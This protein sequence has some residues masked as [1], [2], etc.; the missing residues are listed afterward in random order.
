[1]N[2]ANY[3]TRQRA[4]FNRLRAIGEHRHAQAWI[5]KHRADY[6]REGAPHMTPLEW[7]ELE[8]PVG[9]FGAFLR[10]LGLD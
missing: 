3:N 1:M 6:E 7:A 4:A 5:R 2:D 8:M 10:F 9:V